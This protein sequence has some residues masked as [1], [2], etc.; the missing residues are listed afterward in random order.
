[1]HK[2]V[3]QSIIQKFQRY[4][5][6]HKTICFVG[7]GRSSAGS[8][9]QDAREFP[10]IF[11]MNWRDGINISVGVSLWELCRVIHCTLLLIWG[12]KVGYLLLILELLSLRICNLSSGK[13]RMHHSMMKL[14]YSTSWFNPSITASEYNFVHLLEEV[15][16]CLEILVI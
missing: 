2:S 1:M 12:S 9:L 15:W 4:R 14:A 7:G 16:M 8:R 6:Y 5:L 10:V 3:V 13:W 11:P